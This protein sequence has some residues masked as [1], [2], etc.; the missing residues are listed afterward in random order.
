MARPIWIG[1]LSFGLFNV[2]IRLMTAERRVE[3]HFRM[4]DQRSNTPIRY[5]RVNADSGEEAPWKDVVKAFEYSK[6]NYVVLD[7]KDI[8]SV[9]I[10]SHET[11]EIDAFAGGRGDVSRLGWS[12]PAA[13]G[14]FHAFAGGQERGRS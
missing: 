1:S 5:E 9:A 2:P 10:E 6:G 3:L 13:S 8:L 7:E 14:Q 12:S 11:V 4:L